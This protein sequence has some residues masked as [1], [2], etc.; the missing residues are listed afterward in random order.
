MV[1]WSGMIARLQRLREPDLVV[2]RRAVSVPQLRKRAANLLA[3][4]ARERLAR[5]G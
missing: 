4:A 3:H 2:R 1:T 5:P